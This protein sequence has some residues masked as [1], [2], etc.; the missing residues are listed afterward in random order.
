MAGDKEG[1]AS[2]GNEKRNTKI[3]TCPPTFT[4]QPDRTGEDLQEGIAE[5][6]QIQRPNNPGTKITSGSHSWHKEWRETE[7]VSTCMPDLNLC[8]AED[9]QSSWHQP[10][11]EATPRP[12]LGPHKQQQSREQGSQ[13]EQ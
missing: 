7:R 1:R 8:Q 9:W 2:V 6:P 11:E 13:R 10:R 5:D 4:I 3:S 12:F